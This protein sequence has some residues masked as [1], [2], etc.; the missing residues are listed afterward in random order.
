MGALCTTTPVPVCHGCRGRCCGLGWRRVPPQP[1]PPSL[2][3]LFNPPDSTAVAPL[4]DALGTWV[5][6]RRL[7]PQSGGGVAAKACAPL[8]RG[9]AVVICFP[10][11]RGVAE[12]TCAPPAQAAT[13][14]AA[15]N[16]ATAAVAAVARPHK[17][18]LSVISH[19]KACGPAVRGRCAKGSVCARNN[20]GALSCVKRMAVGGKCTDPCWAC[21]PGLKWSRRTG[22]CERR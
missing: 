5:S 21:A 12:E 11:R 18:R 1:L 19:C 6:G 7:D 3:A 13:T 10:L 8:R 14:V 17:N 2:G 20:D 22:T 4:L 16:A 9:V 15:A